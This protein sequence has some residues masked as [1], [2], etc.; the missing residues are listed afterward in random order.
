M[1]LRFAIYAN[2]SSC[3]FCLDDFRN[4]YNNIVILW[5]CVLN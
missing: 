5:N 4:V 1:E 3:D 2:E